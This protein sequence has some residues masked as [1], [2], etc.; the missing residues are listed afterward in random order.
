MVSRPFP[1]LFLLIAF[2]WCAGCATLDT[3]NYATFIV[4]RQTE[5]SLI[6]QGLPLR[7]GQIIISELGAPD[8]LFQSLATAEFYPYGHAG[9]ISI[10]SGAPWVYEGFGILKP[11]LRGPPTDSASGTIRRVTLEDYIGRNRFVAIYD[12]PPGVNADAVAAFAI[13]NHQR[14]TPFDPYFDYRDH[15]KLYC[16]EF[17]ALALESGGAK[18]YEPVPVNQNPSL[19][20]ALDWLKITAPSI[21]PA[22]ALTRDAHRVALLS[23]FYTP[24]QVEAYFTMKRE[25][26]RRFTPDQRLGNL[27]TWS[28]FT[29]LHVR[30]EI[31]AFRERAL[32]SVAE[33]PPDFTTDQITS[34]VQ[35]LANQ[36]F[37]PFALSMESQAAARK[38][39]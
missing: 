27:F 29:A 20:V 24:A 35:V 7:S 23:R 38:A 18:P 10:E 32:N 4:D 34:R 36:M 11:H 6:Y 3:A 5:H 8:S 26:H 31:R 15:E 1:R 30:P 22:A 12:P 28:W 19:R 17:V 39:F 21:L 9:V 2:G 33:L 16:T 25:L 37:G 14:R 13:D